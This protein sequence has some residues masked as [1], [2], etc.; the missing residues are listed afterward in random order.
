MIKQALIIG[1]GGHA[2]VVG[3]ALNALN[4][5]IYGYLDGSYKKGITEVIKYG[6]LIGVPEDI[7]QL[8]R[9]QYDVY[10]AVGDNHKRGKLINEILALGFAMPA[11]IHPKSVI[12]SDC[13][14]ADASHVCLGANLA[15][16]VKLGR[17]V[18]INTGSSVDHESSIADYTHIAPK[19]V[20]AGRVSIGKKVFIG[21]G[22]CIAQNINIGDEAIIGAG[23]IVLKDVPANTKIFGVFH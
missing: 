5:P 8:D 12:E 14:I 2:R 4:A 22:A 7:I 15:T 23:A 11:L 17:G 10:V 6:S 20:I 18:I 13:N 3:A 16:E 19:V 1:C 21:I 9:Q